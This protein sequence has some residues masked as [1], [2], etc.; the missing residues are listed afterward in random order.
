MLAGIRRNN[1]LFEVQQLV[2]VQILIF[3]KEQIIFID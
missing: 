3:F 1:P 2:G